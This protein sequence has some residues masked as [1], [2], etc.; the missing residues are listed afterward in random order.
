MSESN[1]R[2]GD[3][4]GCDRCGAQV[5]VTRYVEQTGR[6]SIIVFVIAGIVGLSTVLMGYQSV[7]SAIDGIGRGAGVVG[8][9][10]VEK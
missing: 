5:I 7:I 3:L 2:V 8:M 10:A 1:A 6:P 9:C 4:M